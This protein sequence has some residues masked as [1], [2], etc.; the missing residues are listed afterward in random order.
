MEIRRKGKP[1]VMTPMTPPARVTA[2]AK[3]WKLRNFGFT[4]NKLLGPPKGI[5]A[6]VVRQSIYLAF[7][8]PSFFLFSSAQQL[9]AQF[10]SS[11]PPPAPLNM[12]SPAVQITPQP[13]PLSG[14]AS[15]PSPPTLD[16]VRCSRCQQS[17]SLASH[18]SSGAVQF[19]MNSYYCHRCAA[20]VGFVR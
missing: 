17:L 14:P 8:G 12:S 19:G 6:L 4:R 15:S 16:V 9:N 20:K 3:N 1:G 18:T 5:V 7:L 13:Q 11:L 2:E 10:L